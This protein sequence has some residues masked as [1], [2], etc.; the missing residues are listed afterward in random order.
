MLD[1]FKKRLQKRQH[2]ISNYFRK[3]RSLLQDN[4]KFQPERF[5]PTEHRFKCRNLT[6]RVGMEYL[7]I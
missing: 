2:T 1:P 5:D 3:L 4:T 6:F 7:E